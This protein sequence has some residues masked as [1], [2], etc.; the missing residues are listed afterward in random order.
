MKIIF[1]KCC[2]LCP[3]KDGAL[4]PTDNGKWAH[5]I[6]A[7]YIPEISFGNVRT[8]EPIVLKDIRQDRLNK[9][10]S[11]CELE[12]SKINNQDSNLILEGEST[13]SINDSNTNSNSS[14]NGVYV[15]CK[16]QGCK[17]WFHVTW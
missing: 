13:I 14:S 2:E 4:K 9:K 7:L 16:K 10:C 6:C 15:N 5:V 17:N 3:S 1:K 12:S 8:M 11:I